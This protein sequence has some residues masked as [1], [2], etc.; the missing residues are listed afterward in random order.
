MHGAFEITGGETRDGE[1]RERQKQRQ[2]RA[3]GG[4]H[5]RTPINIFENTMHPYK[6]VDSYVNLIF[7]I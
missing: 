7:L 2:N 1:K 6:N 4:I 3:T 5:S